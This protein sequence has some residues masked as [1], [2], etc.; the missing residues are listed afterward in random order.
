MT[1]ASF[2]KQ[3]LER[4]SHLETGIK[5]MKQELGIIKERVVD[6]AILTEEEKQ[7]LDLALQ[8]EREGKLLSKEQ[9]F[10]E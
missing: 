9:I 3:V 2:Q 8:E 1:E 6:D 4:L 5:T 7:D 10:G